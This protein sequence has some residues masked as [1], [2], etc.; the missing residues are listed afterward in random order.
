MHHIVCQDQ[1]CL[2]LLF[3][4]ARLIESSIGTPQ[5]EPES[6]KTKNGCSGAWAGDG[7]LGD[8]GAPLSVFPLNPKHCH[9][10]PAFQG[11]GP[12]ALR[13]SVGAAVRRRAWRAFGG[14]PT[15]NEKGPSP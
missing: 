11:E 2:F 9:P 14:L 5:V 4:Q 7:H 1:I 13:S 15:D 8:A 12:L 3:V 10:E 6:L